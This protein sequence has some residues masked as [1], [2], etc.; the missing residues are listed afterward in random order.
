[1]G[2]DKEYHDDAPEGYKEHDT[3]TFDSSGYLNAEE[4]SQAE[5]DEQNY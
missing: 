5:M 2:D 3:L 1:M 4:K